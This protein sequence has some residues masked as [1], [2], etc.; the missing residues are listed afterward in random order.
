[1][2]WLAAV[3]NKLGY[4]VGAEVGAATGNTT[5]YL[6]QKC[7]NL[8]KLYI[9]DDWRHIPGSRQWETGDLKGIFLKKLDK[10][11][12]RISIR[13]GISWEKAVDFKKGSLD[14]VFIDASHDY[15]SVKKDLLAWEPIVRIGGMVCGH[16]YHFEGVRQALGELC[17]KEFKLTGVD[18]TWYLIK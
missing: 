12:T 4:K 1:M 2:H 5:I 17:P 13:D 15:E 14:F 7:P 18:N 8:K 6:M 3:V 10:Y 11:M 16:D 9:I